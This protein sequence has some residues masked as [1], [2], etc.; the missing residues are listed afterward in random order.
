MHGVEALT[1]KATAKTSN[2]ES[3]VARGNAELSEDRTAQLTL[4]LA[5]ELERNGRGQEAI[6]YYERAA[7]AHVD[8]GKADH[9]LA[10][11]YDHAGDDDHAAAKYRAATEAEPRNSEVW[12][13]LGFFHYSRGEYTLAEPALRKA[14][15]LDSHNDRAWGNLAMVLAQLERYDESFSA[16]SKVVG[17]AEAHSNVGILQAQHGHRE[18]ANESLRK[19]LELQP[20]LRQ[21]QVVLARLDQGG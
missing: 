4:A 12:N 21:A 14:I 15:K 20:S 11:L 17:A 19:A 5:Q 16:F 8:H 1:P 2:A 18:Q 7:A 3:S 9:R 13:D 10:L 6:P